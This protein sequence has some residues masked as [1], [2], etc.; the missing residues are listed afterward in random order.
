[1]KNCLIIL[2]VLWFSACFLVAQ[3]NNPD[4]EKNWPQWR[5]PYA[6]GISPNG[7]PPI[8][9]SEGKNIKWK[10][11]IPGRGHATPV[12]WGD[13]I[14]ISTAVPINKQE[15][16]QEQNE[17]PQEGRRRGMSFRESKEMHQFVVFSI[18][19]QNGKI[20][21]QKTVTEE[22]P[23]ER[24][25][26]FGSWASHSPV[27]DGKHVYA[28]FGSRGLFCL[29]LQGNLKWERD[30][31]QMSKRMS[32][33]EGSSPVLY[34]EKIILLW[35]HEGDSFI[36]A[37]DKNTEKEV[38]KVDRDERTS[39]ST[40]F[41][42]EVDGK[43]QVITSATHRIRSYD[44]ATGKLIWECGGM[45]A[46]CIP[47][48]V[49]ANNVVYIMSGFRG[50]ALLAI[51]LSKAKGDMTDSDAIV[52]KVNKDTPYT[53]SPLLMDNL[54]YFLRGNNGVLSCLDASDGNI[55][56]TRKRLE[57]MGNVFT[58]PVGVKDRIYILG[59][60]G[61]THVIKQGPEFQILAKNKLDDNF[62]ASPAIAG[63]N[64]YLRGFKHLYCISSE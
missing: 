5:G 13:Q 6:N 63:N 49:S 4:Y 15:E 10:I 2:G 24:T 7:N 22:I 35:D 25:H 29:D 52:W 42:I 19:R 16:K 48:P 53:P 43:P 32:F 20:Q 21:W 23:Q 37:L 57:G 40:P 59:G 1:M 8:E 50:S 31:G 47:M 30:F 51:D 36:I 17:Q 64:M 38:W 61:L 14:F 11:E 28:Y 56:Y 45:T 34:K 39:W 18:N 26:E 60:S 12:I 33:G 27:T 62:H 9:W 55:Y 58:S 46:N 41:I 3:D 54:L 44:F